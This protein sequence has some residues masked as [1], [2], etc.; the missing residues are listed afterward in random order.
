MNEETLEI[1]IIPFVSIQRKVYI[2][3]LDAKVDI[4]TLFAKQLFI[5]I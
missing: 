1:I 2:D 4:R 3:V 5:Q